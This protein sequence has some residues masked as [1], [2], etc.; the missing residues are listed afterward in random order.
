MRN[1]EMDTKILGTTIEVKDIFGRAYAVREAEL[2]PRRKALTV[3]IR[4]PR[5][6]TL[7]MVDECFLLG[8]KIVDNHGTVYRVTEASVSPDVDHSV[9]LNVESVRVQVSRPDTEEMAKRLFHYMAAENLLNPD[10]K[11]GHAKDRIVDALLAA[12]Y[13]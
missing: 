10:C 7:S 2:D 12:K 9:V 4:P 11:I 8:A 13:L 6:S 3:E 1:F 5:T